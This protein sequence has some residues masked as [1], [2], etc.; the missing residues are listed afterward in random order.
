MLMLD[1]EA[2]L[3]TLDYPTMVDQLEQM[4]LQPE[5]LVD[6]LLMESVDEA[7]NVNHFYIRAGWQ[8]E[9]ALGAKV[10]TI[11]PRNNQQH[12]HPSIQAVYILFEG[13]NGTPIACLDGTAL[14]YLK[15]ATDSALGAKFLCRSNPETMLMIGAGEMASHLIRAHCQTQPDISRVYIWNRTIEKARTLCRGNLPK[16][17]PDISF[18]TIDSID[19]V[20]ASADLICAATA[21]TKPLISG[22]I[23][24]QGCH[25]DLV[26]A[27]TPEMREADDNCFHRAS[28]FVDSRATTLHHI[29]ELM[30]PLSSGI[31]KE[32]DIKAELAELCRK[33]HPG[34]QQDNEITLYKN[35]GGGHLDLMVARIIHQ[36]HS[37]NES[38]R[39]NT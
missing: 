2:V 13:I 5:T 16:Q 39:H 35:G 22:N 27:Y 14:T 3:N 17:F 18:E 38:N 4:Q 15:T 36:H 32:S 24:K 26:G 31:I 11:F 33:E 12:I 21:T 25:L 34:R 8:P 30:A 6:E 29:G 1:A 28:I 10:I 19:S 9:E 7:S 37:P 20:L 23:L